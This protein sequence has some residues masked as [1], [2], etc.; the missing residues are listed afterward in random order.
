MPKYWSQEWQ[1]ALQEIAL[2]INSCHFEFAAQRSSIL[3]D[4]LHALCPTENCQAKHADKQDKWTQ[5]RPGRANLSALELAKGDLSELSSLATEL[6]WLPE[7]TAS[8]ILSDLEPVELLLQLLVEEQI[9]LENQAPIASKVDFFLSRLIDLALGRPSN[10]LACYGSLR[11]RQKNH[12][13]VAEIGGTWTTGTIRGFV[14]KW[15]GYP[16]FAFDPEGPEIIVDVL[17]SDQLPAA[18][19]R[20]DEFEGSD[21]IRTVVP[22][23]SNGEFV[24]CNIYQSDSDERHILD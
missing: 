10:R 3:L 24:V 2:R 20:L 19:T 13:M 1:D 14:W 11:H 18:Y 7:L 5:P 15:N 4:C 12:H 6:L 9:D 17:E 22:V 8:K 23:K 16:M 21:Y